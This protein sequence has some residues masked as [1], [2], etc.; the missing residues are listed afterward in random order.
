MMEKNARVEEGKTPSV[1]SGRPSETTKDGE[2][3]CKDEMEKEASVKFAPLDPK[4]E[5]NQRFV[6]AILPKVPKED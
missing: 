5:W 6:R 4:S 2:A 3:I 1:H